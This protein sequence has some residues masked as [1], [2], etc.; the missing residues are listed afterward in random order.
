MANT[1]AMA[2]GTDG[3]G[4]SGGCIKSIQR[5]VY[6]QPHINE[7]GNVSSNERVVINI[8]S[9]DPEKS[10]VILDGE[11]LDGIT[12]ISIASNSI[13]LSTG[14]ADGDRGTSIVNYKFSWQ[15]IEFN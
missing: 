8:N 3:S 15:V 1:L 6:N 7:Y 12:L 13:T 2:L 11:M 4:S 14:I 9:I 5:G 10:I